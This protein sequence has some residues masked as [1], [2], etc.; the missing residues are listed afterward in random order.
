MTDRRLVLQAAA[1]SALGLVVLPGCSTDSETPAA[2]PTPD[3]QQA[4]ELALIALYDAALA[5]APPAQAELWQRIR[6]E[7]AAHLTALGWQEAPPT[8]GPPAAMP[9]SAMRRAERAAARMRTQAARDEPDAQKAQVLA[10][11]AASE[12]QHVAALT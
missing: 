1:V 12:A 7:H 8:P 3:A 6:D 2:P 4:D 9:G 11:I 5:A 10:L